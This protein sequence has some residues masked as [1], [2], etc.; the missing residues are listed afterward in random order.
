M[1]YSAVVLIALTYLTQHSTFFTLFC[2]RFIS[3]SLS[4][5]SIFSFWR[6]Q[7]FTHHMTIFIH[8]MLTL[9]HIRY[10]SV[11][12]WLLYF[13]YHRKSPPIFVKV[14]PN[15]VQKF[16][17]RRYFISPLFHKSMHFALSNFSVFGSILLKFCQICILLLDKLLVGQ[18][19]KQ[20][21]ILQIT[22]LMLSSIC[23]FC[24]T[25]RISHIFKAF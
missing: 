17:H 22:T 23:S 5:L 3:R 25:I 2:V 4:V 11:E 15:I 19:S 10:G 1:I 14:I 6:F 7:F 20:F 9:I 21:V 12:W 16:E 24:F 13:T 18:N 8:H